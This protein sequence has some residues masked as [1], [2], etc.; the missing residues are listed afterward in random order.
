MFRATLLLCLPL[1]AFAA[2]PTGQWSLQLIRFGE[3]SSGGRMEL[4]SDGAKLT[5]TINEMKVSGT[6]DGSHLRLTAF[7]PDGKECCKL[8]GNLQADEI[9]GTLKDGGDEFGWKARRLSQTSAA[10]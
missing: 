6:M 10:P 7:R 5:G 1:L 3:E 2:D 8:E 9:S 4:K